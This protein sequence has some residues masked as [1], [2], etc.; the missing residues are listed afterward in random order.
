MKQHWK[1]FEKG[2]LTNTY[3]NKSYKDFTNIIRT[4][5]KVNKYVY[6]NVKET[7]LKELE[8]LHPFIEVII[9]SYL[10]G[11]VKFKPILVSALL[12]EIKESYYEGEE[13]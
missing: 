1:E 6:K 8:Q 11:K 5:G 2:I 7:D 13:E 9:S 3:L 4:E 12:K 10:G